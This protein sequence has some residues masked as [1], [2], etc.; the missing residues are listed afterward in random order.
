MRKYLTAA[1]C[2]PM[3][4]ARCAGRA[5]REG[6]K[7]GCRGGARRTIIHLLQRDNRIGGQALLC[8]VVEEESFGGD[9]ALRGRRHGRVMGGGIHGVRARAA[10]PGTVGRRTDGRGVGRGRPQSQTQVLDGCEVRRAGPGRLPGRARRAAGREELR[11]G[12]GGRGCERKRCPGEN[13]RRRYELCSSA[14]RHDGE[15]GSRMVW[16]AEA[17]VVGRRRA[18]GGI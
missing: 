6:V 1:G 2:Q 7:G 3:A 14:E 4:C 9:G 16:R 8:V 11:R 5:M 18:M 12:K 13:E 15:A 17:E 10:W